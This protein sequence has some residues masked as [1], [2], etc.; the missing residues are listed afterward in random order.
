M[1]CFYNHTFTVQ[2]V[3]L[4]ELA[5]NITVLVPRISG[6]NKNPYSECPFL[7]EYN[8]IKIPQTGLV[9]HVDYWGEGRI[10]EDG[11]ISGF[12]DCYNVNH[13]YQLV[14]NGD[15]EIRDRKIPNR[16]PVINYT[17]CRTNS[18]IKDDSVK[19]VTLMGAPINTSCAT[20]IGR[21]I[22]KKDGLVVIYSFNANSQDVKNLETELYPRGLVYCHGYELPSRL[23]GLTLFDSHRAYLNLTA[24]NDE[25]YYNITSAKYDDAIKICQELS[26]ANYQNVIVAVVDRLLQGDNAKTMTFAYKLWVGGSQDIVT[27]CFPSEF[28]IILRSEN[29]KIISHYYDQALKL[30]ANVDMYNDRLGWGD[31]KDK[32]S[33]RVSWKFLPLEDDNRVAFKIQNNE[34]TMFLK[35]DVNYDSYGDRKCWG[36]NNSN[37]Q[38]HKWFLEP[39]RFNNKIVFFIVNREYQQGLKLDAH[40]D[41]YGDRL[42]WGNNTNN[43]ITGNP[44]YFS[45]LI[46]P[47]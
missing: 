47:W 39:Q 40:V 42:L 31:S 35:L 26:K 15:T 6:I 37:E 2:A 33:H 27:K 32:T 38:R 25:L 14:S 24:F 44:N 29:V 12:K 28:D 22:N 43:N 18:Y 7:G 20:D 3:C 10:D 19:I 17:D 21:I 11:K 4:W 9:E 8:L 1:S 41:I 5:S 46:Q 23:Q 30:D 16:I 36:S 34:H 45:W 13:T